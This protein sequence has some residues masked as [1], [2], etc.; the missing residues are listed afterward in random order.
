[1]L[2][3]LG[4]GEQRRAAIELV[5]LGERLCRS[6]DR[7]IDAHPGCLAA[8]AI[9]SDPG[10]DELAERRRSCTRRG[11]CV[12]GQRQRASALDLRDSPLVRLLQ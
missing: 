10:V 2:R 8:S 4:V 12:A 7:C 3:L 11:A 1:M 5:N 9:S 6:N